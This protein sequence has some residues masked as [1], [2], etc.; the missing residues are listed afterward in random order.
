MIPNDFPC[1]RH[2]TRHPIMQPVT[3]YFYKLF[4]PVVDLL[5]FIPQP[6]LTLNLTIYIKP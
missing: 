1:T 4:L 3:Y 2:Y 5:L 6:Q